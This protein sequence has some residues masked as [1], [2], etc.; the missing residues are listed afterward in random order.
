MTEEE[1]QELIER[2]LDSPYLI[3][4]SWD[5]I[6]KMLDDFATT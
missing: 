2:M 3:C 5:Y 6:K 4:G 1:K